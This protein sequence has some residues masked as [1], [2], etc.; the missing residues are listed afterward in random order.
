VF[1]EVRVGYLRLASL[2]GYLENGGEKHGDRREQGHSA[3]L[4]GGVLRRGKPALVDELLDPDFVRY[5]PYIVAGAVRG[6]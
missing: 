4:F 3:P 6:A 1:Y 2:V 5:D